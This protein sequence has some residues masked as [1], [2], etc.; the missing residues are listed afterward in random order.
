MDLLTAG[1]RNF[2][3]NG[4]LRQHRKTSSVWKQREGESLFLLNMAVFQIFLRMN[5]VAYNLQ[6]DAGFYRALMPEWLAV[7]YSHAAVEM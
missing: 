3:R 6:V 2:G 1:Y 4:C 5:I 7:M